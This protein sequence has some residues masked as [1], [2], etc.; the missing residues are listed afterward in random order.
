M[1]LNNLKYIIKNHYNLDKNLF[2]NKIIR[3]NDYINELD[4]FL[5]NYDIKIDYF[6]RIKV[7]NNWIN[8]TLYLPIYY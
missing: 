3:N 5:N 6:P 7:N 4:K 1:I 2:Y 8:D